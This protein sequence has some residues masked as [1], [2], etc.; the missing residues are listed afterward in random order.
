MTGNT[1]TSVVTKNRTRRVL[2]IPNPDMYRH[3][4]QA[5]THLANAEVQILSVKFAEEKSGIPEDCSLK[6]KTSFQ[7]R[8]KEELWLAA[9]KNRKAIKQLE[10]E[11]RARWFVWR[12]ALDVSMI[13]RTLTAKQIL[14]DGD[15][16]EERSIVVWLAKMTGDI[17]LPD[18]ADVLNRNRSTI[19]HNFNSA[20]TGI[21]QIGSRHH[22][23]LMSILKRGYVAS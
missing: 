21:A 7:S 15:N 16:F 22:K 4:S 9:N 19:S 23:M 13:L 18:I 2:G 11:F 5:A 20:D 12:A 6:R 3:T 10:V 1:A 8:M 17:D 14:E